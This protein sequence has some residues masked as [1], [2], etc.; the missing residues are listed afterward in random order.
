[1]SDYEGYK[2]C[3]WLN[4]DSFW[5]NANATDWAYS[6]PWWPEWHPKYAVTHRYATYIIDGINHWLTGYIDWN[7]VLDSIGGPTH[8]FNHCGAMLMVDYSPM[9]ND[10]SPILYFTPYYY[11]L[12]QFSRSMRPG[13][14]VLGIQYPISNIQYPIHLCATQS[15][16]GS[17]AINI[18]NTG[19]AT[20][21]PLQIGE[22]VATIDMPANSVE[23]II[24]KL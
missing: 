3:C 21:F 1:M 24:V 18:L 20:T 22:Y 8:V 14:T 4:N 19:E 15:K 10:Q 7:A 9:T 5:W 11:V 12:K 23:T 17:I 6:T 16:D 2:E 13:D